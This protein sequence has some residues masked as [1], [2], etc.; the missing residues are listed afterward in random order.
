[1]RNLAILLSLLCFILTG[2]WDKAEFVKPVSLGAREKTIVLKDCEYGDSTFHLIS[3]VD[4]RLEIL[5]GE[6]WLTITE[7]GADSICF[8]FPSNN[9]FKR[10]ADIRLSYGHR[11]DD[12]KVKQPGKYEMRVELTEKS[13]E[14]P[15]E[16][17]SYQV[18]VLTNV[19]QRDLCVEVSSARNVTD[20]SL[21]NN[22]IFFTVPPTGSF[23]PRTYTVTV[24]ASDG[25]GERVEAVLEL[26]QKPK[27]LE[28]N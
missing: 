5:S 28:N 12:L 4:Y 22:R 23:N 11:I 14:V 3:N 10:S 16:G 1:M 19:L 9:G 25:W 15:V 21:V 2:C 27:K 17:G 18:D 7:A 8:S 24:Y 26:H 20:V 13:I 6:D